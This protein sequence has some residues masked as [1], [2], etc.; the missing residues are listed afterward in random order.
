MMKKL[1]IGIACFI[2]SLNAMEDKE[3]LRLLREEMPVVLMDEHPEIKWEFIKYRYDLGIDF[4]SQIDDIEKWYNDPKDIDD[5]IDF[6]N[7]ALVFSNYKINEYDETFKKIFDPEEEFAD[8]AQLKEDPFAPITK[9]YFVRY[10]EL[11][12]H[13]P[14]FYMLEKDYLL[15]KKNDEFRKILNATYK[16]Y[17]FQTEAYSRYGYEYMFFTKESLIQAIKY[18]YLVEKTTLDAYKLVKTLRYYHKKEVNEPNE[19]NHRGIHSEIKIL[20]LL[21]GGYINVENDGSYFFPCCIVE[22]THLVSPLKVFGNRV[23]VSLEENLHQCLLSFSYEQWNTYVPTELKDMTEAIKNRTICHDI[24][25][26]SHSIFD[27]RLP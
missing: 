21:A 20:L 8:S 11:I 27:G 4:N 25:N 24:Y 23:F 22:P 7:H 18:V 15:Q 6:M 3:E 16:C 19:N 10:L 17:D 12:R 14:K 2:L 13:D 5:M 1:I 9:T 26:I